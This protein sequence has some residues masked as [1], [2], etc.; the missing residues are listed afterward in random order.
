MPMREARVIALAGVYQACRMVQDLATRGNADTVSAEAS[1]GSIFRIDAETA[2]DVFGGLAGVRM[3]FEQMI[4]HLDDG[5]RDL[6]MTQLVVAVLRLARRLDRIPSMR[7]ALR[8]GIES[9][10]RQ[11]PHTGVAATPVQARLAELY[12]ETL[13]HVRP[14]VVVHGN[15][16]H[17]GNP[18]D[19]EQIRAMLLAAV[20]AAVLW[21]QVGGGQFRLL[22]RRREYAMLARGLLA[23]CTLDRG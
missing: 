3:G 9:I 2:A 1:L 4:A 12:T 16:V 17:L 14:R 13:S 7:D 6:P 23:R 10:A 15:P 8:T 5:A 20:R 22:L 11:V 19:V 21:R 18:R